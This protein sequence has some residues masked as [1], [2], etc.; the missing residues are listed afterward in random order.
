M[1]CEGLRAILKSA[2]EIEV[3]G[4]AHNGAQALNLVPPWKR[5]RS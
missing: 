4:V 5:L 1:V 3:V 2:A